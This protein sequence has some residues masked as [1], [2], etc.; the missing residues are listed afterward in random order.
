MNKGSTRFAQQRELSELNEHE[1][2][3]HSQRNVAEGGSGA[4]VVP[5]V[6]VK[7]GVERKKLLETQTKIER[8]VGEGKE[9]RRR[10]A[11]NLHPYVCIASSRCRQ[12]PAWQASS[13]AKVKASVRSKKRLRGSVDEYMHKKMDDSEEEKR[14][15]RYKRT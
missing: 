13:A 4:Q 5:L 12:L 6:N 2:K 3:R 15:T 14:S 7:V 8:Y 11:G 9:I 10:E 1:E